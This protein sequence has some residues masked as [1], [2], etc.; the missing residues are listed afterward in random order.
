MMKLYKTGTI[1]KQY[2]RCGKKPCICNN[3]HLHGPYYYFFY[4]E[5]TIV[6]SITGKRKRILLLRKSYLKHKEIKKRTSADKVNRIKGVVKITDLK[7]DLKVTKVARND[8]EKGHTLKEIKESEIRKTFKIFTLLGYYEL[9][10]GGKVRKEV[11]LLAE[12]LI[13]QLYYLSEWDMETKYINVLESLNIG[14]NLE[15][16]TGVQI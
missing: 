13:E 1:H 6:Q 14:Q 8:L 5:P 10:E 7:K 15:P 2:V 4:R 11:N 3:G 16:S 9:L 12:L